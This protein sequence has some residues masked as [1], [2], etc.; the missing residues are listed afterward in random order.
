[1]RVEITAF[2]N[3][4]KSGLTAIKLNENDELIEVKPTN[5]NDDIIMVSSA[6]KLIRFIENEIP[7][8]FSGMIS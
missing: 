6:G 2:D 3:I 8:T 4:R 7:K 5:G 1:M